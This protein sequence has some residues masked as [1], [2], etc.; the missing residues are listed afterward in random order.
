MTTPLLSSP[1]ETGVQITAGSTIKLY[2]NQKFSCWSCHNSCSGSCSL[3][4]QGFPRIGSAC[5]AFLYAP[6]TDELERP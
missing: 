3:V 1:P 5:A 2:T 4:R 6:G